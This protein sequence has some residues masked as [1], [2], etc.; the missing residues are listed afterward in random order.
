MD[1]K[2]VI[3]I[4]PS[5][6]IS[7]RTRSLLSQ[8]LSRLELS[9]QDRLDLEKYI[10]FGGG[11]N[12]DYVKDNLEDFIHWKDKVLNII[13]D[14]PEEFDTL[15]EIFNY[16][17]QHIQDA[18][19]EKG[20]AEN[21][22]ILKGA[23]A[24]ASNE[25]ATALGGV[26]SFLYHEGKDDERTIEVRNPTTAS[27]LSAH[28]EGIGAIASGVGAH[29]EGN[30]AITND[31]FDEDTGKYEQEVIFTEASGR[32]AH[33][34]GL[35]TKSRKSG[36][37]SEGIGSE[38]D[39]N[40]GHVEGYYTK[41]HSG[42]GTHTEGMQT[43]GVGNGAH[44]EGFHTFAKGTAAHAEGRGGMATEYGA[45]VEGGYLKE[46]DVK[47]T[48]ERL[49]DLDFFR[50]KITSPNSP[51]II[52]GLGC[53]LRDGS[54]VIIEE[55]QG[56]DE[57]CL[58]KEVEDGTYIFSNVASGT[59]S[60]SEGA[61]NVASGKAAHAEGLK[62]IASGPSSHAEGESNVSGGDCSHVEGYLN[63]T[64]ETGVHIEGKNNSSDARYSHVEGINNTTS[65]EYSHVEGVGTSAIVTLK[66]A[67]EEN[68]LYQIQGDKPEW[69]VDND[70]VW[71]DGFGELIIKKVY[72]GEPTWIQL[73][74]KLGIGNKATISAVVY[75]VQRDRLIRAKAIG[76]HVEGIGTITNNN[77]EHASGQYN[78]STKSSDKSQATQFSIGIG[79][80]DT[81]RKN[82]FE[83]KENGDTYLCI[84]GE[85]YFVTP[86]T[87]DELDEL[88]KD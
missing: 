3:N 55:Y 16:I 72:G 70:R 31:Y 6:D 48:I 37:H 81:D 75:P 44:A 11:E 4:I 77:A 74:T 83:V 23:N 68:K 33:A 30:V 54:H 20:K 52:A 78:E 87:D 56:G 22:A 7:F 73:P 69:L 39:A 28:A 21:S 26:E 43:D 19:F 61:L 53:N 76:S 64:N 80:S 8:I 32:G 45:H 14:A 10:T 40:S 71:I 47:L 63:E 82:A 65:G 88:F 12:L 34:E 13:K 27:G 62:N 15:I 60:H 29:A 86:I 59:S 66:S 67:A 17:E 46:G 42:E 58:S 51:N 9:N 24:K 25:S 2:E 57:L 50:Y 35:G 85:L 84:R 38:A 36:S 1:N 5:K 79:T 18:P 41:A 49:D